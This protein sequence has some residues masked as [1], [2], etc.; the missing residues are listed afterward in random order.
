MGPPRKPVAAFQFGRDGSVLAVASHWDDLLLGCLGTLV[1]LKKVL[2]YEVSVL[3]LCNSYGSYYGV[4]QPRLLDTTREM[5]GRLCRKCGFENLSVNVPQWINNQELADRSFRESVTLLKTILGTVAAGNPD[6]KPYNLIL[7]P[8]VDDRNDDHAATGQLVFSTFRDPSY[9]L[10]EYP[11][12]R[13]TEVALSPNICVG[14]DDTTEGL[15]GQ[16]QEKVAG[17]KVALIRKICRVNR[18][19]VPNSNRLFSPDALSAR[20]RMNALDYGKRSGVEFA[21]VFRGRIEL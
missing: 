7:C 13:Y 16:R 15:A 6:A 8:P 17:L 18:K 21:E 12:K 9:T 1:K 4:D 14:L 11:I 2:G 20:M 10:L 19:S 3:V 5:Y